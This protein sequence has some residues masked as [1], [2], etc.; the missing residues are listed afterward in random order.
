MT[1]NLLML[2]VL[3]ARMLRRFRWPTRYLGGPAIACLKRLE[4]AQKGRAKP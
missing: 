3:F 4:D 1:Y 2:S